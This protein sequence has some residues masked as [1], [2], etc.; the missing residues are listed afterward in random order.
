MR[1]RGTVWRALA[2]AALAAAL[3]ACAAP[4][5]E[6]LT[7]D[8]GTL[9]PQAKVED[10]PFFA[11]GRLYCG[12]ASM[13]MALAW[14][15]VEATQESVAPVVYTPGREGSLP[16]DM[17][18]APRRYGRL[19]VPVNSLHDVLREIAA[20]HPVIVFQNLGLNWLPR[21]HYAVATGYDL[22]T[23]EIILH[24]AM[25]EDHRTTLSKFEHT[26]QRG[27]YWALV[28]LP[29]DRLPASAAPLDV[30]RGAAGLERVG[31]HKSAALAYAA[32][33]RRWP[34][35]LGAAIGLGNARYAMGDR[36]G[37]ESAFLAAATLHPEA[38]MG[39]NNLAHVLAESGERPAAM[40]AAEE[41]VRRG[42]DAAVTYR[43]TLD[44]ISRGATN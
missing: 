37:A 25:I 32:A 3:G 29:P 27:N 30:L 39:W 15:G 28:V 10:V 44:E 31:D 14:S 13:A 34:D 4:Q 38:P 17:A 6:R 11:Q 19:A 9:P 43:A 12:P 24:S 41:A 18:A 22:D 7:L 40:R 16:A 33:L 42:G 36:Q 2:A 5:A 20:G 35:N 26:W 1:R 8:R 21:W 23:R